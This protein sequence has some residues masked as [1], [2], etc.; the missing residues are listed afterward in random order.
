MEKKVLDDY[1]QF[2]EQN[3]TKKIIF[4]D[5][6]STVFVLNFS[7]GQTLPKHKHPGTNVYIHVLS[8]NGIFQVDGKDVKAKQGD[9][10]LFEGDEEMGFHN[11]GEERVSLYVMLNKIPNENYVKEI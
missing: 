4:N 10:F 1:I 2:N 8:G 7:Q 5:G 9:V 3:F 11:N 6:S